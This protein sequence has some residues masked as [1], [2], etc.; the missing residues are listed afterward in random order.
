MK[1]PA[2]SF[3]AR[4]SRW[5]PARETDAK[6]PHIRCCECLYTAHATRLVAD[7]WN[8]DRAGSWLCPRCT[9]HFRREAA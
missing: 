5:W 4:W 9:A 7:G 2:T 6:Q 1:R 3:V 8:T